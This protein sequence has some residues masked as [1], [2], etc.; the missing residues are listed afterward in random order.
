[1]PRHSVERTHGR[2][3]TYNKGCHCSECTEAARLKQA[4]YR[5]AKRKRQLTMT[6]KGT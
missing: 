3:A 6:R 4:R 1:M 2:I 5:A